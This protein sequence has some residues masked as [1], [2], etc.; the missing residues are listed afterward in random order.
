M[1]EQ[2]DNAREKPAS[3]RAL[4]ERLKKAEQKREV[5]RKQ[6]KRLIRIR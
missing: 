4:D 5:H 6:G 1:S 2:T 3:K